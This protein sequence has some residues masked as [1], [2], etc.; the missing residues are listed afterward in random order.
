MQSG[1]MYIF[2]SDKLISGVTT[3]GVASGK[4]GETKTV[5]AA[6]MRAE[7]SGEKNYVYVAEDT[8]GELK[9]YVYAL[10]AEEKSIVKGALVTGGA[11]TA[12]AAVSVVVVAVVAAKKRKSAAD[13]DG[14]Q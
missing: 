8:G 2:E 9:L 3:E 11:I 6:F 12:V 14:K 5:P 10:K 13:D 4:Y 1:N 7:I